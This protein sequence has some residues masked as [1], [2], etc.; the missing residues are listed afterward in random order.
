MQVVEVF[1]D[2][3]RAWIVGALEAAAEKGPLPVQELSDT[4]SHVSA[5]VQV[6]FTWHLMATLRCTLQLRCYHVMQSHLAVLIYFT[7]LRSAL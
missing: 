1:L 6:S 7:G 4:L 3:R 2:A 5:Q